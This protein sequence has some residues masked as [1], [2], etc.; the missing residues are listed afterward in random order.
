MPAP[1]DLR[2]PSS[3]RRRIGTFR[4]LRHHNYQLYFGGQIISLTGS[5]VQSTAL[6]WL[7]YEVMKLSTWA[8]LVS[9]AQVVPTLLLGVYGGSLADRYPRRPLIFFTQAVFLLLA[10]VLAAMATF[11]FATGGGLFAVA[12]LIGIVNAVDTPARLAFVIDMVGREDLANAI[13]LNSLIFNVA[14]AAGPAL[15]AVLLAHGEAGLCFL[16]NSLTFVAVLLALAFMKLP[17]QPFHARP[18]ADASSLGEAFRY[19][20]ERRG[21]VLMVVLAGALAFFGWPLMTLLPALSDKHLH[22]GH[23]GYAWMMSAVGAGGA[24]RCPGR[25]IAGRERSARPA[26]LRRAPERLL[27]CWAGH[28]PRPGRRDCLLRAFGGRT[29]PVLRDWASH[30]S[31][32]RRRAQ[33][34]ADHGHLADGALRSA[35]RRPPTVGIPRRPLG[36]AVCAGLVVGGDR[37]RRPTR[38]A[39]RADKA[40]LSVGA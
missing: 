4:A 20:A 28:R 24:P 37:P 18:D 22:A 27:P 32:G 31:T 40:T 8:A 30:A 11:N 6:T 21:L 25:R 2:S 33:P 29:H 34:R 7:A 26:D 17:R 10:M 38:G 19:L 36:R 15:G 13:A 9:A 14:R 5:W 35:T 3:E 23:S 1:P 16:F 39:G 12:L